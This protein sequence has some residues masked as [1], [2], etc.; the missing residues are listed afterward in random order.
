MTIPTK[1]EYEKS[2]KN[3]EYLHKSISLEDEHREKLINEL[4][5]SQKIL[6]DY[7]KILEK[8][9]EIVQKYQIYQEILEE[10]HGSIY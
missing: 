8:H 4:C 6:E 10:R 2:M 9:K 1:E 5:S 7:K 3:I